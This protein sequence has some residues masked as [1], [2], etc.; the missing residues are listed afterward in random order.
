MKTQLKQPPVLPSIHRPELPGALQDDDNA[1]KLLK[2]ISLTTDLTPVLELQ[3]NV[4]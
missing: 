4:S 1:A 3:K 2:S